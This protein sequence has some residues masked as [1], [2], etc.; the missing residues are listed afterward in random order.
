MT[1][2]PASLLA[3][4]LLAAVR[5]RFCHVDS[6]PIA[7]KRV[8]LENAGGSLTLK[9][10]VETSSAIDALADN[11][12]RNNATSRH[13]GDLIADGRAAV[14]VFLNTTDGVIACRESATAMLFAVLDA[15]TQEADAGNVVCTN[16]DHPATYDGTAYVCERHG[17]EHRVA[18]LDPA[19][20]VV[21]VDAVLEQ[22]DDETI[23]VAMLH[24]SNVTGG[25]ND[26]D[27]IV[28]AVRK[29]APQAMIIIDGTQFV[30]HARADVTALGV[31]AYA[32]ASYKSFSKVGGGFAYVGPR[33]ATASHPRLA[34]KP[35]TEWDLGTRDAGNFACFR[36]VVSYLEWLGVETCPDVAGDSRARIEAAMAAI[37]AHEQA[38]GE[39]LLNGVRD[40]S[41]TRVLGNPD[42]GPQRQAV[43]ALTHDG[44]PSGEIVEKLV[45]RGIVVH[46]RMGDAYC[47]VVLD[48]LGETDCVRVSLAHYNSPDEVDQFLTAYRDVVQ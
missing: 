34:G 35:E 24:A 26:L 30:Q 14:A 44:Q 47:R 11:A 3:P 17:L 27:A 22:V 10:V 37:G 46:E 48:A 45:K 7:G 43:F 23:V 28:S 19:T 32:F 15:A 2:T 29:R 20:G 16:L 18:R 6:D 1:P 33:L 42:A 12:G 9:S 4:N 8:Y 21:P 5:E 13:L 36:E 41:D 25:L 31:D 38:L 40:I 39:Q